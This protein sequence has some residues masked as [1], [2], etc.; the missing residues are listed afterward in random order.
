MELYRSDVLSQSRRV[1]YLIAFIRKF[2][3]VTLFHFTLERQYVPPKR[4]YLPANPH[5]ITTQ[6]SNA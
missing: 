1:K 5:G 4:W 3:A 6:K 2:I